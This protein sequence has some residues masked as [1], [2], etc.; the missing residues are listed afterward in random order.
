MRSLVALVLLALT[1]CSKSEAPAAAN[2]AALPVAVSAAAPGPDLS[3]L[4]AVGASAPAIKVTAHDGTTF[5]LASLRGKV[6]V[7]YFYPKDETPGCTVEAEGLRDKFPDLGKSGAMLVGVST[8]DAAS[9]KS[10]AEKHSLPF[11]LLPD[12][13]HAIA[14]AFG[15]PI[16]AGFARRVTF[17]IDR[18]GKI[19]K[20][21]PDVRP[22]VHAPEVVEAVSALPPA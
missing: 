20:V 12:T 13:D 14:K 5:D 6:V 9:H 4:L 7:V 22:R 11:P 18:Q 15:V 8:D 10:F 19:A 21:F 17:V 1:A 16:T 3:S 2:S